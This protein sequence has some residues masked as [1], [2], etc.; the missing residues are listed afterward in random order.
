LHVLFLTHYFPP[1][2]G[3]PQTRIFELGRRL[4]RRGHQVT[5]LTGFPNYPTGRIPEP[6]RKKAFQRE[7]IEGVDAVRAWVYATPNKGFVKRL[8]NHLSFTATSIPA[9]LAIRSV[10]VIVVE[11]PPLFLGMAGYLISRF[12]RAPYVLNVADLWPETAVALGA[13]SN[14]LAIRMAEGLEAFLYRKAARVTT[15]T[16]GIRQILLERGL[17]SEKVHLLTN[18]VDTS[19]FC[20]DVD[21][22]PAVE[23]FGLDGRVTVAYAGTHGMAQGLETLVDAAQLLSHDPGIRFI[24]IGEGAEKP[25]LMARADGYGLTN[26]DFFPNQPKSF[27]PHLLAAVDVAVV[28]LRKLEIFASALPSK[29]FEIMA[30]ERPVVLAAVGEAREMILTANAGLV[31]EPE[32]PGDLAH[33]IVQLT[34]DAE[35]RKRMGRNGRRFVQT[36]FD[37]DHL[38]SLLEALLHDVTLE[39]T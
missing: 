12:K 13:L 11:S 1:E 8:L 15:V 4:A 27:M 37:R 32:N 20:P 17:S 31:V 5:V 16:R 21:P 24:M 39:A 30:M 3:A 10:D 35:A 33:A 28:S 18:G 6:Y 25:A 9:S 34:A 29:L 26:L 2:V 14:P 36:S 38:T 22:T 19:F 7:V 23:R